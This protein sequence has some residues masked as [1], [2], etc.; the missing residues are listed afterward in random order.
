MMWKGQYRAIMFIIFVVGVALGF[1]VSED[2]GIWIV[3]IQL[4]AALI[5]ALV[6]FLMKAIKGKPLFY[7]TK[8]M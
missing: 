8:I 6:D 2:L 5:L 4:V 3:L 1:T 7:D